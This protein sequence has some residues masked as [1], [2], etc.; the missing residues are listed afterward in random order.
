MALFEKKLQNL[1]IHYFGEKQYATD[2]IFFL[3]MPIS[4]CQRNIYERD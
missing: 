3:D 4:K 1:I 2:K